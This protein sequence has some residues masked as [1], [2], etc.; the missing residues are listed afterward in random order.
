MEFFHSIDWAA[1]EVFLGQYGKVI[2]ALIAIV[3]TILSLTIAIYRYLHANT[4]ERIMERHAT[5]QKKQSARLRQKENEL[6]DAMTALKIKQGEVDD[7]EKRLKDLRTAFSGKEH[8]LW[9][10]HLPRKPQEYGSR[11]KRQ[12]QKPIIMIA[13]LKGGVSKTTLTANLAAHFDE[14]AKKRVLVIDADYQGSLSNMLLS[15]DGVEDVKSEINKLLVGDKETSFASTAYKFKNVLKHSSLVSAN[16]E[17]ASLENRILIEYL[18]QEDDDDGR[19]R[20]ATAL[21]ND[22]IYQ[23]FD[24]VLIDAPP[25]L[26]AAAINAFAVSTHLLVPTVFDKLS[27]EA[28][29]TFLDGARTLKCWL[30]P[31][32]ELLGIV[33]TLTAQQYELRARE[34]NAKNMA[35]RQVSQTWGSKQHFFDRHIPRRA[36]IAEAAGNDVAYYNDRT[37]KDWFDKL[38]SEIADRLGWDEQT[39]DFQ[40][41]RGMRFKPP[42]KAAT[43]DHPGLISQ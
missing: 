15:A 12:R 20:L 26:T 36:A 25:R 14:F 17:L 1:L 24:V 5:E 29:G 37:V 32:I 28:V 10:L 19:Y 3:V 40:P 18:L 23:S 16:Y 11:I 42:S 38:G 35:E 8:D 39:P 31:E 41:P 4:V 6:T 21:L 9:C 33:G 34:Q 2:A 27:A 13:N 30:N 43:E 7:R 22:D